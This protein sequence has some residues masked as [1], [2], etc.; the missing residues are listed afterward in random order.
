MHASGGQPDLPAQFSVTHVCIHLQEPQQLH[1]GLVYIFLPS[2]AQVEKTVTGIRD[3]G[4]V[5]E[6]N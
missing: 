4:T 6:R 5:P 2:R 3:P 1:I